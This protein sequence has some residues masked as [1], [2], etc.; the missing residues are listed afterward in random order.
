MNPPSVPIDRS[1]DSVPIADRLRR[2]TPAPGPNGPGADLHALHNGDPESSVASSRDVVSQSA[3]SQD[4][5]DATKAIVHESHRRNADADELMTI[6]DFES[7]VESTG[8]RNP[9]RDDT[10]LLQPGAGDAGPAAAAAAAGTGAAST[11]ATASPEP[12]PRE[13]SDDPAAADYPTIYGPR[14]TLHAPSSY[15]EMRWKTAAP[16]GDGHPADPSDL[17]RQTDNAEPRIAFRARPDDLANIEMMDTVYSIY[18]GRDI[19]IRPDLDAIRERHPNL[20][21]DNNLRARSEVQPA[22]DR[23]STRGPEQGP[24]SEARTSSE[25]DD[26][27]SI[28]GSP[29]VSDSLTMS[30]TTNIDGDRDE[31]GRSAE[32]EEPEETESKPEQARPVQMRAATPAPPMMTLQI[33]KAPPGPIDLVA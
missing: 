29:M 21:P 5:H 7:S 15:D 24:S 23:D 1:Q 3:R 33:D 2:A 6:E 25:P 19:E 22:A 4:L 9:G 32:S 12:P 17:T 10:A 30:T 27:S 28:Q 11:R 13:T 16:G 8:L 14:G 26:A 20:D 31:S 18:L